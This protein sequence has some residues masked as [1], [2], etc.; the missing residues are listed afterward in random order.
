MDKVTLARKRAELVALIAGPLPGE[1][2]IRIQCDLAVVNAQI[3]ALNTTEAAQLKAAADRR[4]AAG[5]IE[6]QANAARARARA[7][8]DGPV[9]EDDPS[10]T[11]AIDTWIAAV[12][13]RGGVKVGRA[14]DGALNL[15]DVPMKWA[16][17][18]D[19]LS[20]GIHAAARG[21]ELPEIAAEEPKA[22]RMP[23]AKKRS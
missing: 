1:D 20:A 14:K 10:Q 11:A 6:A 2:R 4:K 18:V 8:D 5:M 13:V 7:T 17:L 9:I 19:A 3:K 12:L 15:F 23:K 16:L 21:E 22:V